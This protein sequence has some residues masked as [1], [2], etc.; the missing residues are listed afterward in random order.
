MRT[1]PAQGGLAAE[2]AAR[3]VRQPQLEWPRSPVRRALCAAWAAGLVGLVAGCAQMPATPGASA[4]A[5]TSGR[6]SLRVEAAAEQP[7]K[8][9]SSAFELQGSDLQGELRLLSPL[10][11]V[12]AAA[13]WTPQ[14]AWLTAQGREQAFADLD[15]LARQALGESLPL[16]A[17]P[18]WLQAQPWAGAPALA[19]DTGFEQLGWSVDTSGYSEGRLQLARAAS[20]AGA[21]VSLRV[22]LDRPG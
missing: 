19:L 10:G 15:D 4:N 22:R 5:W 9:L 21:A 6:L 17:L 11:T 18:A 16:R 20:P 3:A 12:V 1:T 7:A 13:R 2:T 14:G 8:Q